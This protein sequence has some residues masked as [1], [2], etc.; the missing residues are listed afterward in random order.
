MNY[1]F[2]ESVI[3][4]FT[5]SFPPQNYK[6]YLIKIDFYTNTIEKSSNLHYNTL[7]LAKSMCGIIPK[8]CSTLQ[9][10]EISKAWDF[11]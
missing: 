10:H 9:N 1:Q 8:T 4:V 3:C 2:K 6:P 11:Y 7:L 5:L